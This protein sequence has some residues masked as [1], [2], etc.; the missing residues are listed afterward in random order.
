MSISFA[1]SHCKKTIV[2]PANAAGKRGKCAGCG[3]PLTV[4][5]A[6][7]KTCSACGIDVSQQKRTK[8]TAGNYYCDPCWKA[9][10][11]DPSDKAEPPIKKI[12]HQPFD[13]V[14]LHDRAAAAVKSR[15]AVTGKKVT[16]EQAP[17]N[18][19]KRRGPLESMIRLM[20]LIAITLGGSVVLFAVFIAACAMLGIGGSS[21]STSTPTLDAPVP[22]WQLERDKAEHMRDLGMNGTDEELAKTYDRAKQIDDMKQQRERDL[23]N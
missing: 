23:G 19:A 7:K 13:I 18:Q 20:L 4:P 14:P 5:S 6:V 9:T 15:V 22:E 12:V 10:T 8:D 1:C 16:V 11:A 17:R 2:V 3:E 21:G